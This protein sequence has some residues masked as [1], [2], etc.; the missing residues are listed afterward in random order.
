MENAATV[1]VDQS[2]GDAEK[3]LH[4]PRYRQ[5][6][7]GVQ[8]LAVDVL[9][10]QVDLADAKEP[11]ARRLQGI[12]LDEAGMVKHLGDAELMPGLFQIL[13]ILF[14]LQRHH[15][16]GVLPGVLAAADVQDGAVSAAAELAQDLKTADAAD[17]HDDHL[18]AAVRPPLT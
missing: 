6:L 17:V 1:H 18:P 5:A 12:Y 2:L 10:Q 4:Q 9:Y 14:T 7:D 3:D 11:I 15:L 16:E 13:E 8:G